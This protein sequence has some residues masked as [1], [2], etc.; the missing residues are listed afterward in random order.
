VIG[1]REIRL[2]SVGRVA[3]AIGVALVAGGDDAS[4]IAAACRH[5]VHH[6]ARGA[7]V[8]ASEERVAHPDA[9]AVAELLPG[10]ARGAAFA[11]VAR[12]YARVVVN[13]D[14]GVCVRRGR[15]CGVD[16]GVGREL[17]G[18][19]AE[20]GVASEQ[21]HRSRERG[22]KDERAERSAAHH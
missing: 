10:V 17:T 15:R 6:G 21:R 12:D 3:V 18:I 1:L 4:P 22:G 8:G 9:I 7:S 19:V 13:D 11:G 20:D 16:G 5:R 2:A 14:A